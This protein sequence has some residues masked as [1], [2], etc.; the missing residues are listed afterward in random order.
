MNHESVLA[1][2]RALGAVY[3]PLTAVQGSAKV[4]MLARIVQN[5]QELD[6]AMAL[7]ADDETREMMRVRVSELVSWK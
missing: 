6:S 7:I 4:R 5:Q 2:Y 3:P 1:A